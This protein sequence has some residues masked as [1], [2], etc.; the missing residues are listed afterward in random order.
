MKLE[1]FIHPQL[2]AMPEN[3]SSS[4]AA[5]VVGLLTGFGAMLLIIAL[6]LVIYF[7]FVRTGRIRLTGYYS[8]GA[9]DDE[10]QIAEDE[11]RGVETLDDYQREQY[12]RAKEYMAAFGPDSVRT[13][14]TLSQF[15]SIQEKGVSAWEFIAIDDQCRVNSRTE[16]TFLGPECCIHT[17]LPLPRQNEVYYWEVKIHDKAPD[18]LISIGLTSKPY[19]PFRLPGYIKTSF[20]YFSDSTRRL[21]QPFDD[22]QYGQEMMTGDVVGCGYRPRSGSIFFTRNGKKIED[23]AYGQRMN[24]FPAIGALGQCTLHVNLGQMGFVFIEGNVKKWGLAPMVGTLA[25]PPQYGIEGQSILLEQGSTH[26]STTTTSSARPLARYG[27]QKEQYQSTASPL[28]QYWTS[29]DVASGNRTSAASHSPQT[30]YFNAVATS[31][32]AK[33]ESYRL[34]SAST[35]ISLA[36]INGHPP[37]YSDPENSEGEAE[38]DDV[39]DAELERD[40]I[41]LVR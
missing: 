27:K 40:T 1:G 13:D 30:H 19:P 22:R 33:P 32:E 26:S 2:A 39:H 37:A 6:V 34:N 31:N 20:A 10:A 7:R 15:L 41:P 36:T 9:L 5:L 18:T 28:S 4:P 29:S 12:Y 11:I 16:L 17:N 38:T 21:S 23:V 24:L 3:E 25:P 8:P 14:I 35:D